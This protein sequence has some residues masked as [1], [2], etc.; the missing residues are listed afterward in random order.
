MRAL[1]KPGAPTLVGDIR[2]Y[3][4]VVHWDSGTQAW[5]E[6][7]GARVATRKHAERLCRKYDATYPNELRPAHMTMEIF[8]R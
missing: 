3:W 8:P 5:A 6:V 4:T 2:N 7:L 1:E